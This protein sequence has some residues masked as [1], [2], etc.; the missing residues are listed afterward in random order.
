MP[1]IDIT[2]DNIF[3]ITEFYLLTPVLNPLGMLS[4]SAFIFVL[5]FSYLIDGLDVSILLG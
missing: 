3:G 5:I 4:A 1:H 2:I